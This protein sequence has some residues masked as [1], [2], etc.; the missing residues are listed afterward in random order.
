MRVG[1]VATICL[2]LLLGV[3][4]QTVAAAP[5]QKAS[6]QEALDRL[7]AAG[8]PGAV[9]LVRDG[10]R[11]VRL[12]SGYS[13][14]AGRVRA[15]PGDRFRIGSVTKTFVSTVVLQLVGEGKLALDDTVEHV[16]P[17]KL[18]GGSGITVRQLLQQ[19]S[20]LHDYFDD[21]RIIRPYLN[22]NLRY[23]WTP[24]RLLAIANEHKP[25]FRAGARWEYSN[26]NYLVLGLIVEAVTGNS[27]ASELKGRVFDRADLHATTFDTQPA[28][29][30]RHMH[31]YYPLNKELTDFSLLSP[32][33]A[34][35]AGAIV[36]TTDD[37]AQFYRALLSGRLLRADL[38]QQMV[39]TV[40]MGVAS[41][42]YGLGLWRTGTM[43][44]SNTPFTCGVA[45]GHNGDWVG[46]NTNAFNSRDG[47][48]QFVLFVNR[49]E[50][51]FTPKI[52]KAMFALGS[53]AYCGR[54]P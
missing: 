37:V 22:G 46:Y 15:R 38:L 47:R 28:I 9:L 44:L 39:S 7:V 31:G 33:A 8:V 6:L 5:P 51:S 50:A 20:G 1:A 41:N 43:A 53:T 23:V 10:N 26:T 14:V 29:T 11:T 19:T 34:W 52:A 24:S 32:S 16:L 49:D 54:R 48:R 17:G 35:A 45:W 3:A 27:L 12:A 36:S 4:A 30:G 25:D 18:R 40:P 13:I 42:A 21:Q 2:V